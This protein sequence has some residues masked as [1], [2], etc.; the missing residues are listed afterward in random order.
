MSM[1]LS[2]DLEFKASALYSVYR[3]YKEQGFGKYATL[4]SRNN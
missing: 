3:L 2:T 1:P 4:H